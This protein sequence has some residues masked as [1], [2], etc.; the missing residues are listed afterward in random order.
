MIEGHDILCFAPGPWDD[1]WRNRHQ[2]MTRLARRNRVL[3]VEPWPQLRPM[4]RKLRDREIGLTDLNGPCLREIDANL[5]V[6]RPA[7]WAPRAARF[8]LDPA[9]RWLYVLLMRR[10]LRHLRFRAPILWLF[11]PDM[12][13][14]VRH[15]GEKLLIYHVVDEYAG[16][17]GVSETWRPFM[18]AMESKLS[19]MA[20]LV[21]VSSPELFESK[22]AFNEQTYLVPNAV[23]FEAFDRA[24]AEGWVPPADMAGLPAPVAGYVGAVNDKVDL[25]L[26]SEVASAHS[27]C[28][29][30]IVGPVDVRDRSNQDALEDLRRKPNVHFL[31]RKEVTLVPSYVAACDVCLLPY[32]IS[33]WTR[34][35]DSLKLYEYLACGKPVVSTRIP[36]ALRWSDVVRVAES[37]ADFVASVRASL[38]EDDPSRQAKRRSVAA[39]N[40]WERRIET[41]SAAIEKRLEDRGQAQAIGLR[42]EGE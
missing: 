21:F 2:I 38:E 25:S 1:I 18:R 22:R 8:P 11:L 37:P 33:E 23:D 10:V 14:F 35:V 27:D 12:G 5:H 34:N 3:Y 7:Q 36:A 24:A 32:R 26:L 4:L 16:Y 41:V 6:Y 17:S 40:T 39:Q 13:V 9:M 20:D 15:F 28:S 31:G 42:R 29:L 19:G 30:A